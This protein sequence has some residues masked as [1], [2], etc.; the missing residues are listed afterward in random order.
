MACSDASLDT[1]YLASLSKVNSYAVVNGQLQ[2]KFPNDGGKMDFDK[3]G[4]AK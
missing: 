1:I 4:A 3:G 2:F